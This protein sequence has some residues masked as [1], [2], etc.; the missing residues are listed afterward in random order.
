VAAYNKISFHFEEFELQ[1]ELYLLEEAVQSATLGIQTLDPLIHNCMS[2]TSEYMKVAVFYYQTILTPEKLLYNMIYD[3][4]EIYDDLILL[5]D[6]GKRFN[7][8]SNE[9]LEEFGTAIGA[10]FNMIFFDPEDFDSYEE[11]S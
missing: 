6:Q 3:M 5:I 9:E 11:S 7:S 8:L 4:G 10:I 2:S 1:Q